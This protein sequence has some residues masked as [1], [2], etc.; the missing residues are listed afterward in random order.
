MK[1]VK[2]LADWSEQTNQLT[3]PPAHS[4]KKEKY[5]AD[6]SEQSMRSVATESSKWLE[7]N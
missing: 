3:I 4:E 7:L 2:Y 6:W 1:K 5:Y